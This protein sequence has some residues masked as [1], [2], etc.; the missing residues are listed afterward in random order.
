MD[1]FLQELDRTP[2]H[3]EDNQTQEYALQALA[4]RDSI[5]VLRKHENLPLRTQDAEVGKKDVG[6]RLCIFVRLTGAVCVLEGLSAGLGL[7]QV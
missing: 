3:D 4:L 6:L 5:R 7:G 2:R 1:E